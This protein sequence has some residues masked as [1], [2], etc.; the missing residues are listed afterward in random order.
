MEDDNAAC[1]ALFQKELH[2]HERMVRLNLRQATLVDQYVQT[3]GVINTK[4]RYMQAVRSHREKAGIC[5]ERWAFFAK[6]EKHERI[7]EAKGHY[8]TAIDDAI[9]KLREGR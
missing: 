7:R 6:R 5:V 2:Y 9:G 1:M 4:R 8:E 3:P